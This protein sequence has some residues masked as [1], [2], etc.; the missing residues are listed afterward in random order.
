V[1]KEVSAC[2]LRW[3]TLEGTLLPT[4][5]EL[6][7]Q[8]RRRAEEAEREAEEARR[9]AEEA[10]RRAAELEAELRRYRELFGELFSS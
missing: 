1:Y 3:A 10:E 7:V 6:A 8:E 2:W 9:R 4:P 5:Q